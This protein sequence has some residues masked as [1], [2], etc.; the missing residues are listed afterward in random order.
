MAEDI[1]CILYENQRLVELYRSR[2]VSNDLAPLANFIVNLSPTTELR[3]SPYRIANYD[4]AKNYTLYLGVCAAIQELSGKSQTQADAD[5][6]TLFL[7]KH[8]KDLI[9]PYAGEHGNANAVIEIM[10]M[11]PPS[12]REGSGGFFD[13]ASLAEKVLQLR[14]R[15]ATSWTKVMKDA[16]NDQLNLKRRLLEDDM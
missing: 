7:S 6:L 8:G 13:P 12:I 14:E 9:S 11:T 2:V 15:I 5:W 1:P 10:L 16:E 4:L 3:G